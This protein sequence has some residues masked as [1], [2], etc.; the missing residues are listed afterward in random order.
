MDT[1]PPL[2]PPPPKKTLFDRLKGWIGRKLVLLGIILAIGYC[3]TDHK[4][5]PGKA[6][7]ETADTLIGSSKNGIAHGNTDPAKAAAEKFSTQMKAVQ[8]VF[9]KGGSGINPASGGNFLTYCRQ[10]SDAVVFMVHVPEL[11]NYKSAKTRESLA[12]IAWLTAATAAKDLTFS[13]E[14]PTLHVGLRGFSSYGPIWSG[15]L[16]GDAEIK[17]DDLDEKRRIYPLFAPSAS[18]GPG[19]KKDEAKSNN[20][21]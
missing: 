19:M 7:F 8:S 10:T 20:E 5:Y 2:T 13:V 17:T 11:R 15:K 1:P 4:D 9:F 16:R 14:E 18:S 21:G 6:E 3:A 12:T